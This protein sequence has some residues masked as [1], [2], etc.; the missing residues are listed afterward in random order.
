VT[1][2]LL[3]RELRGG[4]LVVVSGF[5]RTTWH[6]LGDISRCDRVGRRDCARS[7][8]TG[9][10]RGDYQLIPTWSV[11]GMHRHGVSDRHGSRGKQS[12]RWEPAARSQWIRNP[13]ALS[14]FAAPDAAH[15][16]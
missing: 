5:S 7:V 12:P 8:R 6:R 16:L 9:R 11:H 1:S 3:F 10:S 4:V 15:P 13:A 14:R 2:V